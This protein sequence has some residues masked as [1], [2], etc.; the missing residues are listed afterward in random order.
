VWG[1]QNAPLLPRINS[2]LLRRLLLGL[3]AGGLSVAGCVY[4]LW[5]ITAHTVATAP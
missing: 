3:L 1:L 4:G 5:V 2:R